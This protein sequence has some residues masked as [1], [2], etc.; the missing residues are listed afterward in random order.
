[1]YG[2]TKVAKRPAVAAVVRHNPKVIVN[3]IAPGDTLQGLSVKYQVPITEIK[4]ENNIW[5]DKDIFARKTLVIPK[6]ASVYRHEATEYE[7]QRKMCIDGF[8]REVCFLSCDTHLF[9]VLTL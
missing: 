9:F 3:E 7:F 5:Q 4:R 6:E 8:S 2:A 1:M